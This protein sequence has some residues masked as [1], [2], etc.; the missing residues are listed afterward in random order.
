MGAMP[1]LIR[2]S[3]TR[4]PRASIQNR[5]RGIWFYPP[6]AVIR[7]AIADLN[8]RI[9]PFRPI[10]HV[11]ISLEGHDS[12]WIIFIYS[13]LHLYDSIQLRVSSWRILTVGLTCII[14]YTYEPVLFFSHRIF[15]C[16]EAVSKPHLTS[17]GSVT[18]FF[19]MLT[20]HRI[21]CAFSSGCALPSNAI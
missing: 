8:P 1:L 6:S 11:I 3:G 7:L 21:C 19:K 15:E 2:L 16:V 13:K 14:F 12:G 4:S 17:E 5:Y 10:R 20:Y 9:E 18:A